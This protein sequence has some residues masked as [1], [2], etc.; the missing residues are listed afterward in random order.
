MVHEAL[1]GR[2]CIAKTKGHH[3]KLVMTIMRVKNSF[4]NIGFVHVNLVITMVK[5][6]LVKNYDPC[7]SSK[8]SSMT[9]MENLSLN[10]KLLTM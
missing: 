3:Q 6:K 4:G 10:F 7:I 1:K 5:I 8:R 2:R 9:R